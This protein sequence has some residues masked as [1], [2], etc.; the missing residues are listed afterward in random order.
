MIVKLVIYG[1]GP[2]A[3]LMRECFATRL[4]YEVVG[5]CADSDFIQD[6]S[7]CGLPVCDFERVP[8]VWSPGD[9]SMFVAIGYKRMRAR[10][11]LFEKAKQ[12]GYSLANYID[13]QVHLPV[14]LILGEN[15]V[16]FGGVQLAPFAVIGDN[17]A[18]WPGCVLSHDVLL[19]CHNYLSPGCVICGDCRIGDLCFLGASVT[20][21]DGVTIADETRLLPGC[22]LQNSTQ[23][24]ASYGGC[25]AKRLK[26]DHSGEGIVIID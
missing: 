7:F 19:G 26:G 12:T 21:T 4:D 14:D 11:A 22:V 25:P 5:F 6:E 18:I 8:D 15:N 9:V 23:S 24:G 20:V 17:N 1:T 2:F 10:V 3:R 16:L 13:P